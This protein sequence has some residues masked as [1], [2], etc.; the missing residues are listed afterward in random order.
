MKN[1]KDCF[2][3]TI[4]ANVGILGAPNSGK[5]TFVRSIADIMQEELGFSNPF[6][7]VDT[8]DLIRKQRD[9]NLDAVMAKGF[10]VDDV[11]VVSIVT[12]HVDENFDETSHRFKVLNG[13]PRTLPQVDMIPMDVLLW[14]TVSDH[15]VFKR[16]QASLTEDERKNRLDTNTSVFRARLKRHRDLEPHIIHRAKQKKIQVIKLQIDRGF[17]TIS[18]AKRFFKDHMNHFA[19][20]ANVG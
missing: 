20:L 14:L 1:K 15:S 8:G 12:K 4:G 19:S 16:F 3:I 7:H 5:N 10:H 18:A 17:T 13:C 9:P 11:S 6:L 2:Q